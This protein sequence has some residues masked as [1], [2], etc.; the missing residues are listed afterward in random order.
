MA[1][2]IVILLTALT[3]FP[4]AAPFTLAAP[5]GSVEDAPQ[6]SPSLPRSD[7]PPPVDPEQEPLVPAP[8][9][10]QLA[11]PPMPQ[12]AEPGLPP[13]PMPTPAEPGLAQPPMPTPAEPE[14]PFSTK[15]SE[16]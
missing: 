7:L 15:T 14:L 13:P 16:S 6:A 1:T 9:P 3:F 2:L 12:P 8:T 4:L 11:G 5:L 10:G